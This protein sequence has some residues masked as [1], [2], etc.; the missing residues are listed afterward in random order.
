MVSRKLSI[1]FL[2][3]VILAFLAGYF[4]ERILPSSPSSNAGDMFDYIM[5]SFDNYYYYD[6]DDEQVHEAF[7]ANMEASI[8]K[9]AELNNDPYTRLLAV[10]LASSPSDD[11]K[12]V[13]VGISFVF[14]GLDLRVGY[15]YPQG[16]SHKKIYPN[17]LIVGVVE[18]ETS[19]YFKDLDH[20]ESVLDYLK[21]DLG[22]TKSLI[23]KNPDDQEE[24]VTI[25]YQEILTPTAYTKDLDET[26]IAYIKIERFA[27]ATDSSLGTAQVFQN[28]L[29]QL[30]TQ[31]LNGENKTLILDL[32]DNPGGALTALHNQG[33]QSMLP[34]ITQQLLRRNL[35]APLFT[36]IPK[37]GT[38][39]SF[40]GGLSAP[41]DYDIKVLVNEH[42]ASAA[43]VLAAAL[44]V[45]GGYELYGRPTYG[46]GVYQNQVRLKDIRNTRYYL[47]YTEGS[48]FYGDHLNVSDTPL[49]VN[50]IDPSG[51][52]AIDMPVY[53]GEM[54]YDYVYASLANYQ[55]FFNVYYQLE[56]LDKLRTDG[57]FDQA[58][59]DIVF[60]FNTEFELSGQ[61][62]H[63]L[64]AR[65]IHELYVDY[66]LDV[67]K[68]DELQHLIQV[69]KSS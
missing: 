57:Y 48:W 10:P 58:T 38:V 14:E 12:F 8:N 53:H 63:L 7:I 29:N 54:S 40:Y 61:T 69:I 64:T 62:I 28:I 34:G 26:H 30:E 24:V 46:K 36:M 41:K 16:A 56:G 20:Q 25:T 55:A 60:Q 17:D 6:I 33:A 37:S 11:E 49:V 32:R 31:T 59:K 52:H 4:A 18:D 39:Q 13:G 51:I 23:V 42:S 9:I 27:G 35:E 21:G 50:V 22:E 67:T 44:S 15:V 43:E 1:L 65:K 47:V 19:I 5:E 68:D 3:S 66:L 2:I 45:E